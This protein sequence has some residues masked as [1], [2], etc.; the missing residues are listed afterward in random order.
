MKLLSCSHDSMAS[1]LS[2]SR[3]GKVYFDADRS[4]L[5]TAFTVSKKPQGLEKKCKEGQPP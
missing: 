4:I 2:P 5:K 1:T 3:Y